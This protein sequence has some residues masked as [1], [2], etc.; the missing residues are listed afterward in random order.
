VTLT[1]LR[2]THCTTSGLAAAYGDRLGCP[3][4][5]TLVDGSP[6]DWDTW[7]TI[8]AVKEGQLVGC[9]YKLA[10]TRSA[11]EYRVEIDPDFW[12]AVPT[13]VLD[14]VN[15]G[16]TGFLA[17]KTTQQVSQRREIVSDADADRCPT[18]PPGGAA[19][20]YDD[21]S[22]FRWVDNEVI[23]TEEC[24][25]VSSGILEAPA[26]LPSDYK[27]GRSGDLPEGGFCG[28]L[29]SSSVRLDLLA[30]QGAFLLV[31]LV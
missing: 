10:S 12:N 30:E 1:E 15:M 5:T 29:A 16:G 3:D 21:S 14:L 13:E 24:V 27:I 8:G 25:L 28:N 31:P 7:T 4:A 9:P 18:D 20:W 11:I 17:L 6:S 2:G 23:E 19:F 22:F 26:V